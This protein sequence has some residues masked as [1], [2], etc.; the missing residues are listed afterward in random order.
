MIPIGTNLQ[1]KK[2]PAAALAIIAMN[3]VFFI[4]ELLLPDAS[5]K[6]VIMHLGFGPATRN[7]FAPFVSMFLTS[8]LYVRSL[9][10]RCPP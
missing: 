10:T 1:R 3:V 7:P 2:F 5:L 8:A 6:W 9:L 4:V